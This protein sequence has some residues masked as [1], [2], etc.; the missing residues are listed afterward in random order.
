MIIFYVNE[1]LVDSV[2]SQEKKEV[3][4]AAT[5]IYFCSRRSLLF[6]TAAE[7]CDYFC[8]HSCLLYHVQSP[9]GL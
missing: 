4:I 5:F 6:E 9:C 7:I 2:S 1:K 8:V 3:E